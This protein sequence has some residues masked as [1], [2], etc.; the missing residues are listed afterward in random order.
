MTTAPPRPMGD[1]RPLGITAIALVFLFEAVVALGLAAYLL[2]SP[3]SFA[4]YGAMFE[5]LQWSAA[6]SGLLAVPPL[7]VAALAGLI[8][9]GLWQS[10]DW[11]RLAAIVTV[12]LLLLAIIAAIAFLLAFDVA[13]P[14]NLLGG[15]V[16]ALTCLGVFIY[17]ARVRL[18][19]ERSSP[20][21]AG[22]VPDAAMAYPA[23]SIPVAA[24]AAAPASSPAPTPLPY[25]ERAPVATPPPI[26]ATA[27]PTPYYNVSGG[28]VPPPPRP[29]HIPESY[30]DAAPPIL[31]VPELGASATPS[32][33]SAGAAA[34]ASAMPTQQIPMPDLSAAEIRPIAWLVVRSGMQSGLAFPLTAEDEL[35]IGR[36][37]VRVTALLTD[38]TVSSHH[39]K[40]RYEHERF[41]IYDLGSTNGTYL[42][43]H[44]IQRQPL[45]DG[46]ELQLGNSL[47]LFTTS[48][49]EA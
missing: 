44:A 33:D 6:L 28:L 36:D 4:I 34:V 43:G 9:R 38:P 13:E 20:S 18:V 8:F 15:F 49:P 21:V 10:H 17:L 31:A 19:P 23:A 40:V 24:Y 3:T 2:L 16:V 5:R 41:V 25:V 27:R 35:L 26:T 12:F 11:A 1:H 39:A 46:D 29:A 37:A 42:G 48:Q 30:Q 14:R 7:L 47:L 22:P 45:L 32:A